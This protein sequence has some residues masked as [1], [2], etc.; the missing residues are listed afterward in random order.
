MRARTL[1]MYPLNLANKLSYERLLRGAVCSEVIY[2]LPNALAPST[3]LAK[4]SANDSWYE[5]KKTTPLRL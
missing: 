1:S 3:L 2:W 5:R 4:F